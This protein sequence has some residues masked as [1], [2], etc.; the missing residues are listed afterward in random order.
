MR[1]RT[2]LAKGAASA[3]LASV[4]L[5]AVSRNAGAQTLTKMTIA[6]GVDPAFSQFYVAKEGGLFEKNGLDVTIN[7]GPSG[8]AMVPFLVNNQVNAAYGS[9]LAGVINHQVDQNIVAV[10]DGTYLSK[11]LNVVGRNVD[12][13]EGLKGKKVGIAMGTGSEIFWRRVVE[14]RGY[15]VSDFT[16]VNVEAPEMLAATERGDIDGF[17]VW[18]PWPTR[19]L[20]AV[21]GTK[22]LQTA[23]GIYNNINFV[24]MNRGWIDQNRATAEK[25]MR[26]LI[27]ANDLIGKDRP[28]AIKMVSKFLKMPPELTTELMPK[29]E[30]DMDWQPRSIDSIQVAEKQLADQKKLKAPLD[31]AKYCYMDLVKAVRPENIKVKELPK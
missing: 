15:K 20:Q 13:V 19:T 9:D 2:L 24:Y 25:F 17:A 18:E 14:K 10:A 4:S 28:A 27:E 31:Y 1:R 3:A 29:V 12:S 7:T 22:I 21:K 16:M 11:W 23:E 8:S 5:G 26:A 6:T 30:Y